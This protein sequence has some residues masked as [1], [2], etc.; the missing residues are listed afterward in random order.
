VFSGTAF[1]LEFWLRTDEPTPM[2]QA[3]VYRGGNSNTAAAGWT[4]ELADTGNGTHVLQLC[5]SDGGAQFACVPSQQE[6][7]FHRPYHV[8]VVRVPPGQ[9]CAPVGVAG[10]VKFY[11][12]AGDGPTRTHSESVSAFAV[13]WASADPM[14]LGGGDFNCTNYHVHADTDEFR[15]WARARSRSEIDSAANQA[16]SC[17]EPGL[18]VYYRFEESS[19][20]TLLDCTQQNGG[21][22]IDGEF[23]RIDSPFD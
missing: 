4:L 14:H 5:G 20:T 23:M 2:W 10:C 19:P 22:T 3:V 16:I 12:A 18:A 13:D 15:I 7:T 6:L 21:A 1:T 11:V 17:S 9:D 8:A